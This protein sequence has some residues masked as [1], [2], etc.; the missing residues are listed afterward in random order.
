MTAA[1]KPSDA[2]PP[3]P[4]TPPYTPSPVAGNN[5]NGW[6]IFD[7][8]SLTASDKETIS[9][10]YTASLFWGATFIGLCFFAGLILAFFAGV[11]AIKKFN[12]LLV[13]SLLSSFHHKLTG[14]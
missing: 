13:P 12:T 10:I 7:V 3:P 2:P 14:W 1:Q 4:Y 5:K 8:E 6:A 11:A 9:S